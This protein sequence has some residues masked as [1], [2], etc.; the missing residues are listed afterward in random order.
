MT[1]PIIRGPIDF[2]PKW[3]F[4]GNIQC[5]CLLV[6]EFDQVVESGYANNWQRHPPSC[7]VLQADGDRLR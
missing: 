7:G 5:L 4:T 3:L 6:I 1:F 2:S